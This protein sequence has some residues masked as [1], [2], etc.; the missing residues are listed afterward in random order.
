MVAI[1]EAGNGKISLV[2]IVS[3]KPISCESY[4]NGE[5]RHII[6]LDSYIHDS[7]YCMFDS[8]VPEMIRRSDLYLGE[9]LS[10]KEGI[11]AFV[12]VGEEQ[13]AW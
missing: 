1:V 7:S 2:A 3:A 13:V 6:T 8:N 11:A 5:S 10:C 4:M 12:G 9:R